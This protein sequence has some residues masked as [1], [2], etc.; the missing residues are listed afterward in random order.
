[1]HLQLGP[2]FKFLFL[3]LG[4]HRDQAECSW[5]NTLIP[6]MITNMPL[7]KNKYIKDERNKRRKK[8]IYR[9]RKKI[10]G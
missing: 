4:Y 7:A 6:L 2:I 1:M 9:R 10:D 3:I 8:Y 5:G